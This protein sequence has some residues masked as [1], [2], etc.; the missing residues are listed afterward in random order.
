MI[1]ASPE[2]PTTALAFTNGVLNAL[3]RFISSTALVLNVVPLTFVTIRSDPWGCV[4]T[5]AFARSMVGDGRLDISDLEVIVQEKRQIIR[6]SGI[7]EF[8]ESDIKMEDVGGLENLK[9]WL[10]KRDKSWL[11]TAKEYGQPGNYVMGA[12]TAGFLKIAYAML[13]QG[14]V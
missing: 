13:D 11:E 10:K 4:P 7:L 1:L 8:I 12:N 14:V 3:Y 2:I 5:T 6:K 9:Q